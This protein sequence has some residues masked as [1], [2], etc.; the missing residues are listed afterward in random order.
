MN[1][2]H[3]QNVFCYFGLAK[4]EQ[5]GLIGLKYHSSKAWT[6][7]MNPRFGYLINQPEHQA[8]MQRRQNHLTKAEKQQF[9][10]ISLGNSLMY[11]DTLSQPQQ[12]TLLEPEKANKR[13]IVL[14][15]SIQ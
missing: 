15:P 4:Q 9:E 7:G 8:L 10:N 13:L 3:W 1:I 6:Q 12:Y 2:R 5:P 11:R 14:Q